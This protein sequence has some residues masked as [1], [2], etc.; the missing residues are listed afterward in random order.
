MRAFLYRQ[1]WKVAIVFLCAAC[2]DAPRNNPLDPALTPP[3]ELQVTLDPATG[4]AT[5]TWSQYTGQ[6]PFREYRVL[7]RIADRVKAD[8]LATIPSI[9]TTYFLDADIEPDLEYRYRV[10]TVNQAGFAFSSPEVSAGS[11]SVNGVSLAELRSD[12]QGGTISLRWAQYRGPDF[13]HYEVWRRRFGEEGQTLHVIAAISDTAWTDTTALPAT[14]Y[15]YW[16]KTLAAGR[17]LESQQ[18]EVNYALPPVDLQEAMFSSASASAALSW[19]PYQGPRFAAYEVRRRA[20]GIPEATAAEVADANITTYLD[21]LL[22]GNT[23][24][25]YR[26]FVRT[27][28]GEETGVFS[29]ER[30]GSFYALAEVQQLPVGATSE[31]QALSLALDEQDQLYTAVTLISTTTARVMQSG[32]SIRSPGLSAYRSVFSITPDRLSPVQAVVG[33]G[34]LYVA[35]KTQEGLVMVGALS[36][37]LRQEWSVSVETFGAIPVGLYAEAEGGV[38]MVDSQGLLYP[39]ASEGV[40]G[41]PDAGLQ[42]SLATDQALPLR[43]LAVGVES[44]L[45]AGEMFFLLAPQ[46]EGHH[47]VGRVRTHLGSRRI[48]G[49]RAITFSDGVG[50]ENGQTLSPLVLAFD[51]SRTRLVVLEAQGRLQV[52]DARAEEVARRYITK[53]GRFGRGEGE[54]QISP[55]TAVSMVVDSQGR[56]YVADGEGR[57]QIFAP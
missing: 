23:E 32:I 34:K 46:R 47:I 48:F 11:F 13:M 29:N 7:R 24:Y 9:A 1:R 39:F 49:G 17:E 57:V 36:A 35:V 28:W 42:A 16:L 8:T 37:E 45:G 33:Q 4:I 21:T 27:T 20:P 25:T 14:D 52:L 55:P 31:I 44:G 6:Q 19:T 41:E 43:H 26:L 10:E 22:D 54:F 50:S 38:L 53:W 15:T 12:P 30:Q 51:T 3:V 56:I 5:L 2:H 40:P 18:R